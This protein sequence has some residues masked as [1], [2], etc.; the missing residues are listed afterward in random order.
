MMA[1][2][3]AW[4]IFPG[5]LTAST[6]ERKGNDEKSPT[7]VLSPL[8]AMINRVMIAG[9][10]TEVEN[11][12]SEDEPLWNGR[13]NDPTGNYYISVGRYQPEAAATMAT[14][15]TPSL[16]AVVGKVRT[17]TS[18]DGRVFISIRPER[19]VN[20]TEEERYA[21]MLDASKSLWER[22]LNIKKALSDPNASVDSLKQM[23]FDEHDA[24]SI[25]MA[26]DTYGVPDS[27]RYLK[28]IQTALRFLL[29]NN[30]VDFGLP[31][32]ESDIPDEIDIPN[33]SLKSSDFGKDAESKEDI[34]LRILQ[35]LDNDSRGV[36]VDEIKRRAEA[37]GITETEVEELS[38]AL[39]DK[40]LVYE[41]NLNYLKII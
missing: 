25:T 39:M 22:L 17:Y 5:E 14:L 2:E 15:E 23:G 19:I 33:N 20:I 3:A 37:E 36:P 18:N 30:E 10:L 13:I 27:S 9:V 28:I 40:G 35:E 41:P 38:S 6:I 4:R 1:R 26:L 31:E 32:N 34:I 29:P 7:Y 21:W 16:V 11:K 12:G 24:E 8:G